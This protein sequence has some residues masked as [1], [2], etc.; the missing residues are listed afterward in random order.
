MTDSAALLRTA[1]AEAALRLASGIA[2]DLNNIVGVIAGYCEM[3]QEQAAEG[4]P[5]Q[6][7]LRNISLATERARSLVDRLLGYS[8]SEL[9]A[10]EP[11]ALQRIVLE[12]LEL[13]R[14][15]L[16]KDVRVQTELLAPA[17]IVLGDE[18]RLLQMTINLCRN[19][20]QAMPSGGLLSVRLEEQR[21]FAPRSC[22]RGRLMPCSYAVLTIGDSG[23]GID[24]AILDRIFDP[25]FTTKSP[26]EGTGLGLALVD[27][28]VAD[29]CG[30]IEVRCKP[31]PVTGTDF[32][33]WLP[34][35]PRLA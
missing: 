25:Y 24:P 4:N 11:V 3:A 1:P 27:G 22:I 7:Y 34:T 20:A 19:A 30:A 6:R 15:A 29:L 23:R 12:A 2:H 13:L 17:A 32:R 10:H 21:I 35:R 33:I 26:G 16:P 18:V 8:R 5:L 14:G 9:A 28:I 31:Q